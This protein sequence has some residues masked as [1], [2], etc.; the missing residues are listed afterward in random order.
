MNKGL[1]Q[2]EEFHKLF[3]IPILEE[4]TI[5]PQDRFNLRIALIEEELSELQDAYAAGDKVE[6]LDALGDLRYVLDGAILELG[7]KN[8]FAEAFDRIH[9]SNMSKACKNHTEAI[10]TI[11]NYKHNKG[12]NSRMELQENGTYLIYRKEDNKVLKNINYKAVNLK[13]LI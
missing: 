3:K 9:T 11:N 5:I 13:D 7:C 8:V 2:V 1:Q 12:V 10:H 4:P 6:I